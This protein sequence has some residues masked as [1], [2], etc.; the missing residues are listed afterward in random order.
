MKRALL[1]II[2]FISLFYMGCSKVTKGELNVDSSAC[3]SCSRCIQVC[4]YDAIE[5]G[6]NGKAIID[7]TKCTQCGECVKICP[8]DA[9]N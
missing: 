8:K 1:F 7:E 9:I 4:P 3:N 2:F 5:F 6:E